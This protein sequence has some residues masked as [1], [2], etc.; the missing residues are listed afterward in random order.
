MV[1]N[2]KKK[3]LSAV[4]ACLLFSLSF[5][6]IDKVIIGVNNVNQFC[7]ILKK[8]KFQNPYIDWSLMISNDQKLINPTN[9]DIS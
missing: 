5:D 2:F 3:N 9:W 4:E 6:K 8:S 7:E 1:F